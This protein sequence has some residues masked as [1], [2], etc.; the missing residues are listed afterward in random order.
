[1]GVPG[2]MAGTPRNL[3]HVKE[4]L[5]KNST[6]CVCGIGKVQVPML[7]MAMILGGHVRTGLEDTILY[8]KGVP[9][10]NRMLVER[11]HRLAKE[12]GREFATPDEAREILSL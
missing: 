1:M 9:A 6:W 8:D 4:S 5:P 12:F 7:A 2:S 10:T 11:V 3:M